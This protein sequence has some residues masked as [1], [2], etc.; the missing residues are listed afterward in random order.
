MKKNVASS[1]VSVSMSNTFNFKKK[2]NEIF[3]IVLGSFLFC[4]G[5]KWIIVNNNLVIGGVTGLSVILDKIFNQFFGLSFPVGL[6]NFV[7]SVPIFIFSFFVNGFKFVRRSIFAM[8]LTSFWLT[9]LEGAPSFFS[10]NNDLICAAVCGGVFCG[11]GSGLILKFGASTGGSDMF[12]NALHKL[13]PQ[14][15]ISVVLFLFDF[16]VITSGFI[17]FKFYNIAVSVMMS[18]IVSKIVNSLLVSLRFARA[19]FIFSEETDKISNEIFNMLKR[20]NTQISCRGMYSKQLKHMLMVVVKPNEILKLKKAI[21]RIDSKA[22]VVICS[23]Q[24]V[25]GN[26]V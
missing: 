7:L 25:L 19:V 5:V 24:E 12:A 13:V 16:L 3:F 2:L 18:Y 6:I 4:V 14:I 20:G 26:W 23:V 22:F 9:V 17:F 10:L 8:L 1:A 11:V 15:P 21:E